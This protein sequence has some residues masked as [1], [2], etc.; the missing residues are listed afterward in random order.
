[1]AKSPQHFQEFCSSFEFLFPVLNRVS[2][3]VCC[4]VAS[5]GDTSASIAPTGY[6]WEIVKSEIGGGNY[7][8]TVESSWIRCKN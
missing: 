7:T 5:T 1:M 3:Y 6:M 8:E 2:H 4:V